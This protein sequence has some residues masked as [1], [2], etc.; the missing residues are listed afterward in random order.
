MV[1]YRR[2]NFEA[3]E[4]ALIEATQ[5]DRNGPQAPLIADFYRAMALERRGKADDARKLVA[6][7]AARMRSVS[8]D[9]KD[10]LAGGTDYDD[11]ILWL[12]YKEA[13]ALMKLDPAPSP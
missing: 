9:E 11:V 13:K 4:K 8:K 12:A 7:T 10:L 3:A 6:A 1:E 2:G 5:L